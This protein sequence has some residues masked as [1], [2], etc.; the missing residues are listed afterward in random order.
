MKIYEI[1]E[2]IKNTHKTFDMLAGYSELAREIRQTYNKVSKKRFISPEK[3]RF[4][5][6]WAEHLKMNDKLIR[7][8]QI[9]DML[10]EIIR[11]CSE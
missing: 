8:G 11:I 6:W 10:D 4:T 2:G 5:L 9:S 1:L 3:K 7:N